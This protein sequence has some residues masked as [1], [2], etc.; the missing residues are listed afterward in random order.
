MILR[1]VELRAVTGAHLEKRSS[2]ILF[3]EVQYFRRAW[4]IIVI[5]GI[6][7][8]IWY[9]F[10]TQVVMGIP[11]GDNPG[12]DELLWFL[13]IGFGMIFP[14]LMMGAHLIVEVRRDGIWL[15]FVPFH[16][17]MWRIKREEIVATS[18]S[19]IGP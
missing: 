17:R 2:E 18:P 4:F 13:L 9:A 7:A 12:T 1:Q 8:L 16:R 14:A 5:F 10:I 19:P 3:R 15:R 6:T 11:F